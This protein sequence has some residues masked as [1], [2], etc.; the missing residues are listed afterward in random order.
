MPPVLA[1][2]ANATIP[3]L[4]PD[5]PEV[6]IIHDTWLAAVHGHPAGV[7]TATEP[8]NPPALARNALAVTLYVQG[9]PA[10]VTVNAK[11]AIVSVPVRG[12]EDGF[13]VIE[14]VTVWLPFPE[15]PLVI[16]SQ[17]ESLAAVHEQV[18]A[19]AVTITERLCAVA[20]GVAMVAP[21]EY[22]HAGG[23]TLPPFHAF[24]NRF[25]STEPNPVTGS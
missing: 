23:G 12:A 24:T 14:K 22:A 6:M 18:A 20:S 25:A 16:A 7:E 9:A 2:T 15:T 1:A 13:A 11:P 10:C 4:F 8:M 17:A 3:L 21:S 19:E 5:I